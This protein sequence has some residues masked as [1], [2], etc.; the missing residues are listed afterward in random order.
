MRFLEG[1]W[2]ASVA[3]HLIPA[4]AAGRSWQVIALQMLLK[5]SWRDI[6]LLTDIQVGGHGIKR[7]PV[8]LSARCAPAV[9]GLSAACGMV[10][11]H[12]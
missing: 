9:R 3:V 11:P 5:P 6:G 4:R 12:R 8:A 2:R 10:K 7:E 1:W